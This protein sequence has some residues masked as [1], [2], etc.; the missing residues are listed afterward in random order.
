LKR[1]LDKLLDTDS[2]ADF[3]VDD[4]KVMGLLRKCF[5]YV[6]IKKSVLK[7]ELIKA[8]LSTEI[9]AEKADESEIS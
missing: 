6:L 1:A 7:A 4:A 3:Q 5:S 8:P 2:H 9:E